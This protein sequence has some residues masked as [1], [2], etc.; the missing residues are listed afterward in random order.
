MSTGGKRKR[1]CL[2]EVCSNCKRDNGNGVGHILE[3]CGFPGGKFY[4]HSDPDEGK[5]NA[6]KQKRMDAAKSKKSEHISMLAASEAKDHQV[7]DL[8]RTVGAMAKEIEELKK[9]VKSLNTFV[10]CFRK[11]RAERNARIAAPSSGW[12]QGNSEWEWHE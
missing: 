9:N 5:R 7:E 11:A 3:Y 6:C 12:V 4:N 1:S 2:N 10:S 8:Q